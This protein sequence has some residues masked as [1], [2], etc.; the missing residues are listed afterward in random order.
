M[1]SLHHG[2]EGRPPSI[3]CGGNVG[4]RQSS[5]TLLMQAYPKP[6]SQYLR[7]P[8]SNDHKHCHRLLDGVAEISSASSLY[9]QECGH[10]GLPAGWALN[11]E[12]VTF[13][14]V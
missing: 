6:L 4:G 3:S 11:D 14:N 1:C 10:Q 2:S 9:R 13:E 8:G 12:T 7:P 5:F